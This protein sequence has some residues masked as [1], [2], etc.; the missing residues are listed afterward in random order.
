MWSLF[1]LAISFFS[2]LIHPCCSY[3]DDSSPFSDT[4]RLFLEV[5]Q[6]SSAREHLKFITSMPHVAGT[7]EDSVM[8]EYVQKSMLD[9]GIPDVSVF[10][11]EV[12]LNYPSHRPSLRLLAAEDLNTVLFTAALSEDLL[13]DTSDTF[14]RNHTFHGYS[15]SGNVTAPLVFANYGRPSDFAALKE[16]L[17]PVKGAIVI[18]RYGK[19]FRGLKVRNAQRLGAIGVLIYSDPADDGYGVGPTYPQG[20]WRPPSGV[21][22]GSVQFNSA[23]AGD[24]MRV[25]A[26]YASRNMTLQSIC[27]IRHYQD[28]IPKIP[29]LPISSAD[30]APLLESLGGPTARQVFGKDFDGGIQNLDYK[31]GPSVET[32]VQLVVQNHDTITTIPNVIGFIPGSLPPERDMPVLLGNHRD[33]W[34]VPHDFSH[35]RVFSASNLIFFYLNS[36]STVPRIPTVAPRLCWKWHEDSGHYLGLVG[37]LAGLFIYSLGQVKNT[38]CWEVL[39]GQNYRP[40]RLLAL[41]PI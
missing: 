4:E 5:P 24:P 29:S 9:A 32:L 13:D 6:A 40:T 1:F 30:A 31:V 22:R 18:V 33:A 41:W 16:A 28:W 3:E 20:P 35:L 34:Y 7:F 2:I 12:L 39:V 8:A 27:G 23:C 10:E 11:L 25:D 26:R 17:V 21:Q 38:A 15:P 37:S 14:W 19:C 36:G